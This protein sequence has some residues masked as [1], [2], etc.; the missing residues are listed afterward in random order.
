MFPECPRKGWGGKYC[1]LTHGNVAQR[2]SKDQVEW[3]H[4]PFCSIPSWCGA[5]RTIWDC[6]WPRGISSPGGAAPRDPLQG[7]S[8]YETEWS[9][10]GENLILLVVEGNRTV[11]DAFDE[12][13]HQL[14]SPSNKEKWRFI[15]DASYS[16]STSP[17]SWK[18]SF[19]S[20]GSLAAEFYKEKE[21]NE[22]MFLSINISSSAF[23]FVWTCFCALK[24]SKLLKRLWGMCLQ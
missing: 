9:D 2:L 13:L 15:A 8:G 6:C 22:K 21:C 4:L 18:L 5:S 24:L 12:P 16:S 20:I 1:W 19:D 23:N 7:K 3:Q 10:S 14:L 11:C 17:S